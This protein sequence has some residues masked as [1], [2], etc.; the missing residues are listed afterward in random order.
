M[1]GIKIK[2]YDI[3]GEIVYEPQEK[4]EEEVNLY[5]RSEKYK[6][7][8]NKLDEYEDGDLY[9]Y[10]VTPN[11]TLA[12]FKVSPN[13]ITNGNITVYKQ[14]GTILQDNELVGTGMKIKVTKEETT[15]TIE[16]SIAVTGDLNGDGE[17]D[18]TDLVIV[19]RH[20]QKLEQINNILLFK[21]GNINEDKN[22]ETNK[23]E[24]DITDLVQIRRHIQKLEYIK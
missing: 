1:R 24:V 22:E 2:V 13:C 23:D 20:I 4:Q 12:N 15:K 18:I 7:G 5:L 10:R 21:A 19:R 9:L 16:L 14:D 6:I 3:N 17:A 11:T 8:E